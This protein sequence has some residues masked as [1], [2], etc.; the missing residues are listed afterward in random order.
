MEWAWQLAPTYC[1]RAVSRWEQ[2]I[3]H[4][5]RAQFL[6]YIE[7]TEIGVGWLRQVEF[8]GRIP[9]KK[10]DRETNPE[11]WKAPLPQILWLYNN[12][13]MHG[14][15]LYEAGERTTE[16]QQSEQFPE[17]T[18]T[19]EYFISPPDRVERSH[20]IW[21]SGQDKTG[22]CCSWRNKLIL[23]NSRFR[24]AL[25]KNKIKSKPQKY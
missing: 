8:V 14:L 13:A 2:E 1:L 24:N 23:I 4:W 7:K 10:K 5:N 6:Q 25:S 21:V 12:L 9:E 11:I 18:Q 19:W 15:K 22:Y 3:L 16:K 17:L 20:I